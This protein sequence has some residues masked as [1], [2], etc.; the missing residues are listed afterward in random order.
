M[1][2]IILTYYLSFCL[3]LII[4]LPA[5]SQETG[6]LIGD[7]SGGSRAIPVHLI[8]LLDEGAFELTAADDLQIPY[9]THQTCAKECHSYETISGGWHFNAG[10][11]EGF[12]GRPGHPWIYVDSNTATIIPL[13]YRDWPG[14]YNPEKI[15]LSPWD[16][17]LRFGRHLPGGGM[18]EWDATKYRDTMLRMM[19]SGKLEV[20]CL[21]CHDADPAH[22]QAEY[23]IQIARQN[24][25]W[26]AAATSSFTS[27]SGSAKAMPDTFD[28]LMPEPPNDPKLIPPTVEYAPNTFDSKNRVFFN[29]VRK[30]PNQRCYFCHSTKL[31]DPD[32]NEKWQR[33]EDVHLAAGMQCVDCHRNGLEHDIVRGYKGESSSSKNPLADV[34]SCEGCHLGEQSSD[35]PTSGRM[36]APVPLH[37]GIPPIHFDTLTCTACHSGPWPNSQVYSLKTSLAHGLGIH[38]INTSDDALPWIVGPVFA[39]T[40]NG[41]LAPHYAVWPSF[42][43]RLGENTHTPY[44]LTT[45]SELLDLSSLDDRQL[46]EEVI[47]STLNKLKAKSD[48]NG[49]PSFINGGTAYQLGEDGVLMNVNHFAAMPYLWPMAHDVRPA[50]QSLGV[51]SCEDCHAQDAPF[52]F[53]KVPIQSPFLADAEPKTMTMVQFEGIDP[54]STKVFALSFV[55][56]PW[57]KVVLIAVCTLIGLILLMY[58]LKMVERVMNYLTTPRTTSDDE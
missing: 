23:A 40:L 24:L 33:D 32:A 45:I 58:A 14:A 4:C 54:T 19:V 47:V 50:A 43:T 53:G 12:A 31:I 42:W 18:T 28:Y 13:S 30:V 25:R 57:Y 27:V 39:K 7:K 2:N 41:K 44:T 29:I 38:N 20:N 55:F 49:Q 10:T 6:P 26:A 22:D 36:A 1:N 5:I 46:T 16:F 15:G 3:L 21:A 56:R 48:G 11:D 51:R 52:F 17:A 37:K 9:S 8:P 35:H 34:L